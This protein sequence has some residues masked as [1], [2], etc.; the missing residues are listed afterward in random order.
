MRRPFFPPL[1]AFLALWMAATR[2]AG[3]ADVG[4][5]PARLSE[6]GLFDANLRAGLIEFSPQ[7]PLWSD[8]AAKRRWIWLPPG[9]FIDAANSNAWEFPRGTRLWKEFSHGEAV[10]TRYIER[11]TD[12]AWRFGSYVPDASGDARLAPATGIRDLPVAQAPGGHYAIPAENDCRACHEG[13]PVPVLGFSALQL[14]PDRDPLAP[15]A[16]AVAANDLRTLAERGVLRNLPPELLASAP[17]IA[18]ASPRERAALGYLHG[19]CGHCHNADGPLAVLELNLS[20]RVGAEP[21]AVTRSLVDVPSQI[22]IAGAPVGTP[23][24]ARGHFPRSAIAVRMRSRDP[25]QQMPPLGTSRI[26]AEALALLAG[27]ADGLSDH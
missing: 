14:S 2:G 4:E 12:G 7:Y 6:T 16:E 1:L 13:A 25:L 24:L 27:W 23:R 11:G 10:E 19:N 26:D 21:D 9:T 5:L 15:H 20:Q 22:S 8:G 18:A 17:R 3:A